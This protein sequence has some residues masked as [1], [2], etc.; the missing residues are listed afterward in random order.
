MLYTRTLFWRPSLKICRER[1]V[2]ICQKQ[3]LNI[4]K[5]LSFRLMLTVRSCCFCMR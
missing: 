5:L 4:L 2:Q 3:P 1:R